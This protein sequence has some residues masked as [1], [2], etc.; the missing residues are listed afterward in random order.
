MDYLKTGEK[1]YFLEV[2]TGLA[3]FFATA[4]LGRTAIHYTTN[5]A[6]LLTAKLLPLLPILLMGAAVWRFYGRS[7]ELQRQTI[8]KI[9]AAA[10]LL[11]MILLIAWSAL[12]QLGLPPLTGQTAIL[13]VCGCYFLCSAVVKFLESRADWGMKQA[14]IRLMPK[15]FLLA[16]ILALVLTLNRLLPAQSMPTLRSAVALGGTAIIIVIYWLLKRRVDP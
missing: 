16:C 1:R 10:G 7:D 15:L 2:L 14:I 9:S 5:P 11:S 4:W 3:L 8:L 6:L 12:H 13:V